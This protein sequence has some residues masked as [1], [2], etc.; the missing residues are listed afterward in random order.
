MLS[1]KTIAVLFGGVSSEHDV[2]CVSAASVLDNIDE[3]K[4]DIYKVGITKTGR[5]KLFTGDNSL[6]PN[7]KWDT[8]EY[9][10]HAFIPPDS[11]IG[12]LMIFEPQ[13][14]KTL[15]LDA[16]FPVLHG[17][18]GEDGTV[19]GLLQLAQIPYV[20]CNCAVSVVCMD[21]AL[22][23]SACDMAGVAQ[24]NWVEM[25]K[26]DYLSDKESCVANAAEYLGYPIF[27][28][29]ANAGSSVGI[30]KAHD[31]TEL[32]KGI[33]I[34][35]AE[36]DKIVLEQGIDGWEVECAVL[37]NE[38]PQASVVGEILPCNEFYDY[39]AKYQGD[40]GLAIPPVN[41]SEQKAQ[42][43]RGAAVEIYKSLGCQGMARM[44]FFVDKVSGEVLFNEPNTLPGF[45]S[46]SMYPKL[47]NV[48]GIKYS[49]LLNRLIELA[50]ERGG[51]I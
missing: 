8:P 33:E 21:K 44:D 32:E 5:W 13:G 51:K 20:G 28:K 24:A 2:S 7:D 29:P 15:K 19:Q 42:E 26:S 50:L 16:V 9:T 27:V 35:F 11:E 37:G 12:G 39:Q 25:I 18:N 46:I 14:V 49:D 17:K 47:W 34:A 31:E 41:I 36:D 43:V 4:F 40:S 38:N 23:N 22:T 3:G 6:L 48:S 45:T 30:T 10:T 1:K